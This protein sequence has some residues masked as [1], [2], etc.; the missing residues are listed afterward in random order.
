[1]TKF[2]HVAALLHR[3]AEQLSRSPAY[4]DLAPDERVHQAQN[5]AEQILRS[6]AGWTRLQLL[7]S[8]QEDVDPKLARLVAEMAA[9]RA[10]G[11]PIAYILGRADFYGHTFAVRPGCLIP[12]PDTE[13]LVDAAVCFLR[14]LPAG[15]QVTDI[16]TGSGC[17]A[18]SMQLAC[19][20]ARVTGVD[21]AADALA[22][23]REN[24]ERLGADVEWVLADGLEWLIAQA[25]TGRRWHAIV[26]NPPYIPSADIAGLEP[27]VSAY[28]P[29]LALDGGADGLMFYRQFA[30]LPQ[31]VFATGK[32]GLFLEVGCGQA[33]EV[34]DLF[35]HW[36]ADGFAIEVIRDLRGIE[37]VVKIVRHAT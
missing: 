5:E 31:S 36:R 29:R 26:S 3:L 19:P 34:A 21:L 37:R 10:F 27:S 8:L 9:R 11:E 12:R 23:A 16:G 30:A 20:Q 35:A 24:G 28:E 15:A 33:P 1:M 7:Q 6:V 14:A 22:I 32:A 17:I 18:I 4:V 2:V 25:A 13:I